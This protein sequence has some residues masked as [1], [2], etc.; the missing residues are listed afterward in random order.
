VF[1]AVYLLTAV[2]RVR[3]VPTR[4][5]RVEAQRRARAAT[6]AGGDPRVALTT[7]DARSAIVLDDE[8]AAND[9]RLRTRRG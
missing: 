2:K 7:P 4:R 8:A 9:A 5:H 6:D 1:G 3:G